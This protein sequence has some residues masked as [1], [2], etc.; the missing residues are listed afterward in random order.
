MATPDTDRPNEEQ[1]IRGGPGADKPITGHFR[2]DGAPLGLKE[3]ESHGGYQALRTALAQMRPGEVTKAVLDSGLRGRGG[4]GFPA[5]RKWGFV[6]VGEEYRGPRFLVAN[7]DEME[8]GAFKDRV[9]M[10]GS[11]HQLLE[12]M[13][14]AAYAIQ[15]RTAYLFVR[16]EYAR[17]ADIMRRAIAD[18]E[19]A[20]Y[21][22]TGI[23]GSG[24]DLDLH[25]HVS[26]G[27]Y[28]CGEASAMLNALEGERPTP[29]HKPPHQTSS[30]LWSKP[31]VVNNVETLAYVPPIVANGPA[32]FKDLGLSGEGGMKIYTV[33][34]RVKR[35]GAWELPM[36]TT[37]AELVEEHA[38]GMR[39]GLRA[40]AA[41]P[42]GGSTGFV[43]AAHFHTPMDDDSLRAEGSRLGT[44]TLVLL[45]EQTCPVAMLRNLEHFYAQ[46]SCGWCTPCWQGLRWV[47]ELLASIEEGQGTL[48]D[49]ELLEWH[50][51]QIKSD[52]TFCDLAPGAMEPL[53]SGLRLFRDDFLQHIEERACPWKKSRRTATASAGGD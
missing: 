3:Y 34:G 52:H 51:A 5:G 39:L 17:T 28:I 16:A 24:F 20:G 22:G 19:D 25:L 15:A 31:T 47:E 12:G 18:A 33:S 42:G 37:I 1:P 36:G 8:P 48:E 44:G 11:P 21:L 46:E 50:T 41:L 38:G 4:A 14:I 23:L 27:R 43:T 29:R 30:G 9:I 49:L 53:E 26:A 10:E 40:R 35:P 6:E 7:G 45:D 32:W 2:K 13:I